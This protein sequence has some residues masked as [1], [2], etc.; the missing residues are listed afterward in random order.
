MGYTW[1][2]NR[3]LLADGTRE[4]RYNYRNELRKVW[5]K[6]DGEN[7]G[8]VAEYRDSCVAVHRTATQVRWLCQP[9]R[10]PRAGVDLVEDGAATLL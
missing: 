6:S 8:R 9:F 2:N 4:F 1:D 10:S 5:R 7:M 3:N